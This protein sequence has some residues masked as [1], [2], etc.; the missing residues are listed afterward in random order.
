VITVGVAV[1]GTGAWLLLIGAAVAGLAVGRLL[2]RLIE[3]RR[4][5]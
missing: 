1:T 2:G 3:R 5:R 4:R